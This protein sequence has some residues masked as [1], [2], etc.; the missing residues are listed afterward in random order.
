M[1]LLAAVAAQAA[2]ALENGRLYR[3]LQ[4]QG[5]RA[6]A[7]ARVQREHPRVAERRPRGRRPRRPRRP[8]EPP[9]RRALRRAP[10]GRGRPPARRDL[11]RR[12]SSRCCAAA[13]RESPEG[14]AFYRVPL[15]DPARR[16]RAALLVNVATTPLRDSDG[17]IAGTILDHRGHLRARAARGAAADLGED[18]VDRPARRRRRA[19]GEHAA[20][21]HLELHADAAGGRRARRSADQG[22]REDRAADVP[23]RQDRQRPA[24]PGA[25]GAGRQRARSTSTRSSTT[26]SRCSSTSSRTGSIQVRKELAAP[27]PVVQGIEYKLQQVF[28][29][30]FLNARDAMPQRRLADDRH[31]RRRATARRSRSP[32]PARAFPPSSCRASTIRSSRPRTSARAPASAC[33]SP[34]ASCRSTAARSPATARSARAP[35]SRLSLPLAVGP[36]SGAHGVTHGTPDTPTRHTPTARPMTR[37]GSILVIDDE[38]IMREILE[39]LLT[40]EGYRCASPRTPPRASSWPARCR[41]TPRSST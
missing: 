37:T 33:R 17:A 16:R 36:A 24:E 19:R 15:D 23:R 22:A 7:D 1:A 28:L 12:R 6:R 39:A 11:R 21:R 32:T 18:G 41:S 9:A 13:R 20:H 25:A 4:R 3:Q 35:A 10:R 29:N 5:G 8:L 30:L 40:R 34:T 31:P 38:E 27:A 26:C 14:A 2:T